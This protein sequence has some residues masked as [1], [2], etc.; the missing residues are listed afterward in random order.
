MAE[1][2][3]AD[4]VFTDGARAGFAA[5]YPGTPTHLTHQLAGH[6]LLELDAL[7]GLARRMRPESRVHNAAV[8]RLFDHA[9]EFRLRRWTGQ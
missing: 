3:F 8:F 7:A 5:A 6:P 4:P 2:V 1:P 9:V